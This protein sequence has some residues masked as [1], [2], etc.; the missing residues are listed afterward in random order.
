LPAPRQTQI[1]FDGRA[2]PNRWQWERRPGPAGRTRPD[3]YAM[4]AL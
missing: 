4:A 3:R 1:D 2:V